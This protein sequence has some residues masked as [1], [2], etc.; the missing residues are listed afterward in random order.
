MTYRVVQWATGNVGRHSIRAVL[1][2]PDLELAGVYVTS[3]AK[4]GLD[5][6]EI[7]GREPVGVRASNDLEEI[8]ALDA[9][10]VAHMPLP[11]KQIGDDPDQD[12]NDICRLLESGKNVVTT[13][14]FVYP[15]AYGAGGRGSAGGG[16]RHRAVVDPRHRR[17]PGVHGR[18]GAAR[19]CRASARAS[20]ASWSGS[21][22]S[23]PATRRPRSS[24]G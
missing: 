12:T 11:S 4:A 19:R 7:A 16:L 9:D 17:E 1:D 8:L 2:H 15:K 14:G 21:R 5:A 10:C 20:T 6:G 24:S 3:P 13:V 18:A 23:S 22:R